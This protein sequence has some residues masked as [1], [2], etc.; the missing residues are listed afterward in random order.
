VRIERQIWRYLVARF[1]HELEGSL[2][3]LQESIHV[4]AKHDDRTTV[5]CFT[6]RGFALDNAQENITG[7]ILF[8]IK[9][10]S[11]AIA[12]KFRRE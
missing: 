11:P 5:E 4:L 7:S 10:I 8:Y 2:E 12:G 1:V 9:K 3:G 6:L